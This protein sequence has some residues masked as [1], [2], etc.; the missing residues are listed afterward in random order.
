MK[1]FVKAELNKQ[2][3]HFKDVGVY[4]SDRPSD[5]PVYISKAASAV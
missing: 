4:Q 2:K 1:E 5:F 3:I